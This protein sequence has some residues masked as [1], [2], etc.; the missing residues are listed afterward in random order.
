MT[1][2]RLLAVAGTAL[3]AVVALAGAALADTTVSV[4]VGP[5]PLPDVPVEICVTQTDVSGGVDECVA[6]PAGKSVSL[7][8]VVHTDTPQPALNPPT[9]TPI[10]CP[11]GTNGVAAEVF[12]GSAEATISGFV[13]LV[14]NDGTPLTIPI[15]EVVAVGGQTLTVFACAGLSPGVPLPGL[16]TL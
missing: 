2:L 7:T 1:R 13:T 16:P 15:D 9:L 3:G 14:L 8:V 11:S 5:V 12:T 6:S 10:P 4:T